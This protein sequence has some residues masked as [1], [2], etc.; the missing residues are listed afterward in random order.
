M[1]DWGDDKIRSAL[2]TLWRD[3]GLQA[4]AGLA[5]LVEHLLE[6]GLLAKGTRARE[7]RLPANSRQKY[8][9]LLT[10]VWPDWPETLDALQRH[11][12]AATAAGLFELRR[13]AVVVGGVPPL[14]HHKTYAALTKAHSKLAAVAAEGI[15]LTRDDVLR[16]RTPTGFA[17][18]DVAGAMTACDAI[19]Q[20][21][22]EVVLPE[23]SLLAGISPVPIAL[24]CVMTVENLGAYLDMPIPEGVLLAHQPGWNSRL[25]RLFI[26]RLPQDVPWFHFGDLD[27][28]GMEIYESLRQ[29]E[30]RVVLWIPEL[31]EDYLD[32]HYLPLSKPWPHISPD[33][34]GNPVVQT[35]IERRHWLEQEAIVTDT[36]LRQA[37][38]R[39]PSGQ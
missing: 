2:L 12:L 15:T 10:R 25:S 39:L 13:R 36:R 7:Y 14:L 30:S 21:L 18:T 32:T 28:E 22:G 35:L 38:D 8:E 1:I 27:P 17:L 31:W 5:P 9:V 24:K 37:L 11:A 26:H 33:L 29:D 6:A 16:L 19:M 4:G 23:R 20:A 34:A 3:G